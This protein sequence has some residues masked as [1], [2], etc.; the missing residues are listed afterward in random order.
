MGPCVSEGSCERR[1]CVRRLARAFAVAVAL[2]G[3]A[4]SIRAEESL[5][6]PPPPDLDYPERVHRGHNFLTPTLFASPFVATRFALAHRLLIVEVPEYPI[7][8]GRNTDVT[9]LGQGERL[10]ISVRFLDRF[11]AFLKAS[12]ELLI[13]G[14]AKSIVAGGGSFTYV[15]GGGG[16]VRLLRDEDRELSIRAEGSYGPGGLIDVLALVDAALARGAESGDAAVERRDVRDYVLRDT[17]RVEGAL[18]FLYAHTLTRNFGLQ[19]AAGAVYSWSGLEL[20]DSESN[21]V[22]FH[23]NFVIPEADLALGANLDPWV[24]LGFLAEYSFSLGRHSIPGSENTDQGVSHLVALGAH[25]VQPRFQFGLTFARAFGLEPVERSDL[26]GNRRRSGK[27]A[28]NSM[29]I[30]LEYTWW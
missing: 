28:A 6:Y 15:V 18:R 12:G 11:A 27:P 24:P 13:G 29:Q 23:R 25:I 17:K 21:L 5:I 19:A 3:S 22:D 26:L 1:A 7:L 30:G 14:Q 16:Q 20:I 2:L 8:V 9:L 10:D 4:P